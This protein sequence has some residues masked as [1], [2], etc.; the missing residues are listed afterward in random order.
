MGVPQGSG[1]PLQSFVP[2]PGTKG[3]PLL[4]LTQNPV[5]TSILLKLLPLLKV[6]IIAQL[7]TTYTEET[8]E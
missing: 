5:N 1:Y 4:S 6:K 7:A 2:N 3:F 8:H